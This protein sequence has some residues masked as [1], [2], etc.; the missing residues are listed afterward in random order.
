MKVYVMTNMECV[1]GIFTLPEYC[2]AGP[3]NEYNRPEGG[4]Y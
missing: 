3:R 2:L 4:R 1:A